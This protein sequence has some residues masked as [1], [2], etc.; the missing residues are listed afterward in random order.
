MTFLRVGVEDPSGPCEEFRV[1]TRGL[2]TCWT[3]FDFKAGIALSAV[4]VKVV[5]IVRL[6]DREV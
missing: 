4:R 3:E 1:V 6:H 5:D 2:T